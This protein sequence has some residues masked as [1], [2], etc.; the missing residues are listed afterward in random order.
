MQTIYSCAVYQYTV[1][2]IKW[3]NVEEVFSTSIRQNPSSLA[4]E[5][6]ELLTPIYVF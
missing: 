4:D 2:I 6:N 5:G 3:R 1:C